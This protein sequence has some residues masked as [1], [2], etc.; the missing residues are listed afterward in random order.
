METILA[1]GLQ[2]PIIT[3]LVVSIR[4]TR[5][6]DIIIWHKQ[7]MYKTFFKWIL[8]FRLVNKGQYFYY[9][10]FKWSME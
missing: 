9:P 7:S 6:F 1:I 10:L 2:N 8:S 4:N 5:F 3:F